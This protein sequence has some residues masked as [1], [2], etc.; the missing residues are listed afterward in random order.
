M[1]DI[2][3]LAV[4]LRRQVCTFKLEA[5]QTRL[6]VEALRTHASTVTREERRKA[7][8][9]AAGW[10]ETEAAYYLDQGR[11]AVENGA[12]YVPGS[13]ERRVAESKRCA[14]HFRA[15]ALQTGEEG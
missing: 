4:A 6:I 14:A 2:T 3:A 13:Y 11:R 10:H 12:V 1:S 9:E 7:F 5:E 15:A 8:E